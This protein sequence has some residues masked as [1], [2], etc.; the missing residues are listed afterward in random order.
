MIASGHRPS[1]AMF[2]VVV[3]GL[4]MGGEINKATK[5]LESMMR[6]GWV[7]D[8]F[9][10]SDLVDGNLTDVDLLDAS[11]NQNNANSE[12]TVDLLKQMA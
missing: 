12:D 11:R 3:R 9:S 4:Q 1:V 6:W 5:V 8:S 7:S 10:L 2:S